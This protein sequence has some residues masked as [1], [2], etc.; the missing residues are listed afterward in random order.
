[1]DAWCRLEKLNVKELGR[2]QIKDLS[3]QVEPGELVC[4]FGPP[5]VGK[6]LALR[7]LMGFCVD[8]EGVV[9]LQGKNVYELNHDELMTLRQ[10]I[11]YSCIHAP[12]LSNLT[13]LQNLTVPL[14]FHGLSEL[15]SEEQAQKVLE[16]FELAENANMRL[17][18][19]TAQKIHLLSLARAF[20][21]PVTHYVL[22][23]PFR[24][25]SW[26]LIK[27]IEAA[28]YR[29]VEAGQSILIC[30]DNRKFIEHEACRVVEMPGVENN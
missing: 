9:E 20:A 24:A 6:S 12:P 28:V 29:R 5:G 23:E 8:I 17:S 18:A 2:G 15:E 10:D 26:D 4:L 25:M 27:L 3:L 13:V 1:M 19:L 30:T 11:G 16:E 14:S 21:L 22:A 7:A